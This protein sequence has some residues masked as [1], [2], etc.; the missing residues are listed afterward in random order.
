M[1]KAVLDTI[2]DAPP[3]HKTRDIGGTGGTKS[4]TDAVCSRLE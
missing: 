4:F 3:E 2:K 1:E